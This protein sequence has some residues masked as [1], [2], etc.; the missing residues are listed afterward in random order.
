MYGIK[1]RDVRFQYK[2]IFIDTAPVH[3]ILTE[4]NVKTM[5]TFKVPVGENF[6]GI[7]IFYLYGWHFTEQEK[8]VHWRHRFP[9]WDYKVCQI[10]LAVYWFC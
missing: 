2:I 6:T 1:T 7:H 9:S 4:E 8:G 10:T 3:L 5:N